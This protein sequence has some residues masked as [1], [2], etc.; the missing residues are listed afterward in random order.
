MKTHVLLLHFHSDG[1]CQ[2]TY[3]QLGATEYEIHAAASFP[4]NSPPTHKQT[5]TLTCTQTLADVST[6]PQLC[7]HRA[8]VEFNCSP[9]SSEPLV[10]L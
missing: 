5:Y 6:F 7:P 10:V 9:M 8:A 1:I 3:L 2:H 4:H